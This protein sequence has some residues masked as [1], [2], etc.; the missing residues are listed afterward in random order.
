M[1]SSVV[2]VLEKYY[3][4][5][6]DV[7]EYLRNLGKANATYSPEHIKMLVEADKIPKEIGEWFFKNYHESGNEDREWP[8]SIINKPNIHPSERIRYFFKE[9]E[10][11]PEDSADFYDDIVF[12]ARLLVFLFQYKDLMIHV[13]P[14]P[15]STRSL[16]NDIDVSEEF[17]IANC[18]S[19][20]LY[21]LTGLLKN[22]VLTQLYENMYE[23]KSTVKNSKGEAISL[24]YTFQASANEEANSILKSYQS[25]MVN[26]GLKVWMAHW[27]MANKLGSVEYICPMIEIMK[28]IAEEDRSAFFSVKEK[29]EHWAL[30]KMLSMSKLIR[31][32]NVKKRGTK[33]EVVQW[34]EQ[35]LVEIVGGEKE[36]TSEDKYPSN[37]AVRVLMP[38]MENGFSP[39]TYKNNTT[40]LSPSDILLAF[41]L[42]T[43]AGQ[44]SKGTK[45]LHFDWEF[46]FEAGNLQTTALSNRRG[47]RAKA[48]NKMDRLQQSEIIEKWQE[49]LL[50]VC[51]TP[52]KQKKKEKKEIQKDET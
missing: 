39:I 21:H 6:K 48:R 20:S 32:K 34:V 45:D 30:T 19:N 36:G 31:E 27:I 15:L 49:E 33:T 3:E 43:R 40:L 26:K 4:E 24:T 10:L 25:T 7:E 1:T 35:N 42:Q 47:A 37:V 13:N 52:K 44:M 11:S 23:A 38:R 14:V 17:G 22:M 5:H 46:I 50:G 18:I 28:L 9:K 2:S 16:F 51:V 29:E 12:S 8:E 41:M